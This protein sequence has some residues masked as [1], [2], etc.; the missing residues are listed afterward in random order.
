MST[1]SATPR[2]LLDLLST[3]LAPLFLAAAGNNPNLAR[4]AALETL[5]EYQAN[6]GADLLLAAQVIGF[7]LMSLS[8]LMESLAE[9]LTPTA[10]SRMQGTANSLSRTADRCRKALEKTRREPP[11]APP[12]PPPAVSLPDPDEVLADFLQRVGRAPAP[13]LSRPAAVPHGS[14]PHASARQR[15]TSSPAPTRQAD[16]GTRPPEHR[17]VTT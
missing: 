9:T 10:A 5:A 8:T 2:V 17:P 13:P 11:P 4:A 14:V 7:S 1:P 16:A 12:P 15:P 6:S 3:L